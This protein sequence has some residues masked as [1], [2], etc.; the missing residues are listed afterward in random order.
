MLVIERTPTRHA[1]REPRG[2]AIFVTNNYVALHSQSRFGALGLGETSCGR[3]DRIRE[4]VSD[5]RPAQLEAC[6]DFLADPDVQMSI[7][8]Q[9]MAFDPR[10]G[11]LALRIP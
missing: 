8:V 10:T 3:F 6:L 2:G 11:A 9:Q 1:V 4:L 7:T 5:N